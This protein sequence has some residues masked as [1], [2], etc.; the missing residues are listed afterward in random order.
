MYCAATS[1]PNWIQALMA[2]ALVGLTGATLVVLRRYAKDTK[3]IAEKSVEQSENARQQ[4]VE[5]QRQADAT[6]Q[7]LTL[8]KGQIQ[9]QHAQ[10]AARAITVL[11]AIHEDVKMWSSTIESGK[12]NVPLQSSSVK[13]VPDDWPVVICVG[14]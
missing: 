8:L 12:W 5:S 9:G 4:V 2:V 6:M 3:T 14:C 7:S 1:L 13:F 11:H 10:E